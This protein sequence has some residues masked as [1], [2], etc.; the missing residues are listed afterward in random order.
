[1]PPGYG[2]PQ[3]TGQLCLQAFCC[4]HDSSNPIFL[5]SKHLCNSLTVET[6]SL[7]RT[8]NIEKL[9]FIKIHRLFVTSINQ[10]LTHCLWFRIALEATRGPPRGVTVCVPVLLPLTARDSSSVD[11]EELMTIQI[12]F[13]SFLIR[14]QRKNA[15]NLN[16]VLN[17]LNKRSSIKRKQLLLGGVDTPHCSS[18]R[19]LVQALQAGWG[20]QVLLTWSGLLPASCVAPKQPA[21]QRTVEKGKEKPRYV[22]RTMLASSIQLLSRLAA[23]WQRDKRTGVLCLLDGALEQRLPSPALLAPWHHKYPMKSVLL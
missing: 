12:H 2:C 14:S 1:M 7:R 13:S 20:T 16:R 21:L 17:L 9:P 10:T 23:R 18:A 4:S 5:Q 19:F 11:T 3:C 6:A 15:T 8:S 22:V